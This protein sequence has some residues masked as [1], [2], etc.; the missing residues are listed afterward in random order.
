MAY[1]K[2]VIFKL[3]VLF[4]LFDTGWTKPSLLRRLKVDDSKLIII[5]MDG[6]MFK[7]IQENTMPFI[8]EF[9]KNGVHC[10]Q[11]QPVFPTKTLVNHFSIATGTIKKFELY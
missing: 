5:S 3:L 7:Q 10:P 11:L 8:T 4:L 1:Q 2:I 6:L 9:Y